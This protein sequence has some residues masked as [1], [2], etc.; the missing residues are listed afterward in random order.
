MGVHVAVPR[1]PEEAVE[2]M[3]ANWPSFLAFLDCSTQW[4]V[5]AGGFG[6]LAWLGLDYTAC[7]H[8]LDDIAAPAGTFSDIRAME[9]A[10]LP[11][12]NEVDS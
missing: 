8:V 7:R 12:L 2:I 3:P 6:G 4:R 5:A 1:E 9:R 10:A 11:V